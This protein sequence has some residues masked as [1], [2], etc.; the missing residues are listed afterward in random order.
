[1]EN[2]LHYQLV[3]S[4]GPVVYPISPPP[5]PDRTPT[6]LIPMPHISS[7]TSASTDSQAVM[8]GVQDYKDQ[9]EPS[10]YGHAIH[11]YRPVGCS[12]A[13]ASNSVFK[14]G[15]KSDEDVLVRGI[16][17]LTVKEKKEAMKAAEVVKKISC[18]RR[19]TKA[20]KPCTFKTTMTRTFPSD[21]RKKA[22]ASDAP[23]KRPRSSVRA[24]YSRAG[25]LRN[26]RDETPHSKPSH[27]ITN[28]PS[29]LPTPQQARKPLSGNKE[30]LWRT[31]HRQGITAGAVPSS[32]P[33]EIAKPGKDD[34]MQM[35][36]DVRSL[37][38]SDRNG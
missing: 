10:I 22:S 11:K 33:G 13:P 12:I 26:W 36:A 34:S 7:P 31:L 8:T 5:T 19:A 9:R 17:A 24:Q 37:G 18:P 15:A 38:Q 6:K 1:M 20:P 14:V 35:W 2:V 30:L 28:V 16:Q 4:S 27:L 32:D 25:F 29:D 21:D 3:S 23:S